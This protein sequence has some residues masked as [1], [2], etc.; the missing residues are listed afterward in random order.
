M[1]VFC[2]SSSNTTMSTSRTPSRPTVSRSRLR[3][4]DD[5][6]N[7]RIGEHFFPTRSSAPQTFAFAPH[8]A[9]YAAPP[10]FNP[11][12]PSHPRLNP[13]HLY[14]STSNPSELYFAQ[15]LSAHSTPSGTVAGTFTAPGAPPLESLDARLV[16]GRAFDGEDGEDDE[17]YDD[18][19]GAVDET[20]DD[21]CDAHI[22][23]GEVCRCLHEH[24]RAK[25]SDDNTVGWPCNSTQA[26]AA[27]THQEGSPLDLQAP[28][29]P[30]HRTT[31]TQA[32]SPH[33]C[34]CPRPRWLRFVR[35]FIWDIVYAIGICYSD[36]S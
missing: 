14:S 7:P 22:N 19:N 17:D 6:P 30:N 4:Q 35:A 31:S 1:R 36:I 33:W 16:S 28:R 23:L 3:T 15:P 20:S 12:T 8:S 13:V 18:D 11:S 34:F 25:V 9:A 21:E 26:T 5:R 27:G 2:T 24:S 29:K 10:E 32:C